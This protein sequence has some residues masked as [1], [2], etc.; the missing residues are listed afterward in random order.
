MYHDRVGRVSRLR[1]LA[2][3]ALVLGATLGW[4]TEQ[5]DVRQT[6]SLADPPGS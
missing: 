6:A 2:A 3:L 5:P 1:T 4:A